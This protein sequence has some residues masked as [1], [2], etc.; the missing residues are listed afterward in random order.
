M[1][2]SVKACGDMGD[3]LLMLQLSMLGWVNCREVNAL[4]T[5]TVY[6]DRCV[7][8]CTVHMYIMDDLYS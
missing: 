3:V 7:C 8:V 4:V 5:A 1:Y 2:C 6:I